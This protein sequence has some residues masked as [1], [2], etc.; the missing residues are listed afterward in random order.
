MQQIAWENKRAKEFNVT[1][2]ALEFG[3]LTAE[4][5]EAFTAWRSQALSKLKPLF[6]K[7]I[8]R[9]PLSASQFSSQLLDNHGRKITKPAAW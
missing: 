1:D 7:Q 2:V 9:G 4:I 5:G 3:L 6:I 8:R